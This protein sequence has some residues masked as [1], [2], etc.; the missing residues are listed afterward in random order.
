MSYSRDPSF[1]RVPDYPLK[2]TSLT[3][4]SSTVIEL[5]IKAVPMSLAT[6][7]TVYLLEQDTNVTDTI[8]S[9][10]DEKSM[11]LECFNNNR[12][13]LTAMQDVTPDCIIAAN[14]KESKEALQLLEALNEGEHNI[15]VIV[16]GHHNDLHTAVAVIK[17]GAVDYIEKPVIYGRLAEH[18]NQI[19]SREIAAAV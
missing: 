12:D 11:L 4:D 1:C 14:E 18:F 9:L 3:D 2:Q 15:P 16:L 10:C 13:L 6:K 5:T 19:I 8:R 17:A 7:V